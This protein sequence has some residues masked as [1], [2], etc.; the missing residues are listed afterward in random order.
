MADARSMIDWDLAVR[1]G[2]R[3]AGD[4]PDVTP[5]QPGRKGLPALRSLIGALTRAF[6]G[7]EQAVNAA[8]EQ[9]YR[10]AQVLLL[11]RLGSVTLAELARDFHRRL[12]ESGR[13]L[14]EGVHHV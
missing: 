9:A 5:L 10:D 11:E 8:L 4:G 6:A 12:S 7:L 3:L 1:V 2:S 13:P 14:H